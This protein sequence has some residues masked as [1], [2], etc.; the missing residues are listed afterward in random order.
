LWLY[1]SGP[2]IGQRRFITDEVLCIWGHHA[3]I[4]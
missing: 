4:P 3:S 2:L 1:F